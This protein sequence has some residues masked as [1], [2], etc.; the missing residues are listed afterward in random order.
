VVR[1]FRVRTIGKQRAG[2]RETEMMLKRGK[3]LAI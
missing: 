3:S 2:F 1:L